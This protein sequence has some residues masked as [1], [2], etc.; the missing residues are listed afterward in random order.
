MF[1]DITHTPGELFATVPTVLGFFPQE[2]LVILTLDEV[3]PAAA[4]PTSGDRPTRYQLGPV[5]RVNLDNLDDGETLGQLER[6]IP[7]LSQPLAF[8]LVVSQEVATIGETIVLAEEELTRRLRR[9][10]RLLHANRTIVA[11]CWVVPELLKG[12][13]YHRIHGHPAEDAAV[14]DLELLRSPNGAWDSGDMGDPAGT[15]AM[16]AIVKAGYTVAVDREEALGT[17]APVPPPLGVEGMQ[18]VLQRAEES[19]SRLL[20]RGCE[21]PAVA[22]AGEILAPRVR[23]AAGVATLV[24]AYRGLLQGLVAGEETPE[25]LSVDPEAMTI[26]ATVLGD[27]L[28]R[29]LAMGTMT[30][31]YAVA[32]HQLMHAA[33]TIFRGPRR[34]NAL[35]LLA[36][37]QAGGPCRMHMVPAL[38][39]ACAEDADHRL[40]RLALDCAHKGMFTDLQRACLRA[41]HAVRREYRI[42]DDED[43]SAAG[44]H[45]AGDPRSAA[46]DDGRG[47][48]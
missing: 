28:L 22:A 8:L 14:V 38:M 29:D 19:I 40:S 7:T 11:G 25:S 44:E 3:E 24:R 26:V 39:T 20:S 21:P 31:D 15:H 17:F 34:I 4:D 1:T 6:L 10:E 46:V 13:T 2:S 30:E 9:V 32:G 16:R 5:L 42:P 47:R 48:A 12:E 41:A 43:D 27:S 36:L 35:A 37:Y 23:D 33:A 45:A 18:R